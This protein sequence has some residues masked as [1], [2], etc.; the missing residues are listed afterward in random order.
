V[1][2]QLIHSPVVHV[3]ETGGRA[4]G[5]LRWVHSACTDALTLYRLHDRRGVDGIDHLGVLP[6]FTGVAIHDGHTPYRKYEAVTHA[7][8]NVHHLRQLQGAIETDPDTQTWASE[9]DNLLR[10]IKDTVERARAENLT[11]LSQQAL[12]AFTD[13]YEQIITLGHHQNPPP[14]QRTGTRGPIARS[15]TANLHRRLDQDRQQ[16]LRFAT[17][18]ESHSTTT[19]P[20]ATY[21]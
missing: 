21:E 20:N 13:R 1:L 19:S 12:I 17:T 9:M 10:E 4:D 3:D 14:T 15:K 7:L 18:S 2:E 11:A 8:C 5:R 16:V 6:A